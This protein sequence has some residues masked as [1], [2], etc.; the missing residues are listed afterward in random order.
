MRWTEADDMFLR[1]HVGNTPIKVIADCLNK[2]VRAV[3]LYCYRQNIPV[4][5]T[6]NRPIL[7]ELMKIK[8]GQPEFFRPNRKFFDE[9]GISQKRFSTL[10]QG[11][12]QPTEIELKKLYKVWNVRQDESES[13]LNARQLE[14][15]N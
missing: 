2:T 6:V 15:F 1:K 8:F 12:A 5:Q 14:L 7:V 13:L 3:K 11:Y 9:V 4:R 10:R